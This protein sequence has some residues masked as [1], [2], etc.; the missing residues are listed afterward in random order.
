MFIFHREQNLHTPVQITR[1]PV[2]TGQIDLLLTTIQEIVDPAVLQKITNQ[3]ADFN[4][5]TDPWNPY[6]QTADSP[7]HQ[8]NLYSRCTGLI[9]SG[10]QF[11]ITQRIHLR[12]N[13]CRFSVFRMFRLPADHEQKT[14]TKPQRCQRQFVPHCRFGITGQHVEYSRCILSNRL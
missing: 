4:I 1:H 7:Y 11:L 5:L 9:K 10:N 13:M 12:H 8:F 2:R 3:R 14:V 6:L